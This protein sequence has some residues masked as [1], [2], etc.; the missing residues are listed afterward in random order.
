MEYTIKNW[1]Y[2]ATYDDKRKYE[3]KKNRNIER[4]TTDSVINNVTNPPNWW[5]SDFMGAG[6]GLWVAPKGWTNATKEKRNI[7]FPRWVE[8]KIKATVE[9]PVPFGSLVGRST[10]DAG[11]EVGVYKE[12]IHAIP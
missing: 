9:L 6:T 2:S 7:I 11:F 8:V 3:V 10:Y 4:K 1:E 5:V 12:L